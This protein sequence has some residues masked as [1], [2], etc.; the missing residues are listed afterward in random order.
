[1][2]GAAVCGIASGQAWRGASAVN[3]A[4]SWTPRKAI[5]TLQAS[6]DAAAVE[7]ALDRRIFG[8]NLEWFN[9][10]GGLADPRLAPSLT[11]LAR[12]QGITV[13]RF[14]GGTLSDYYHW[15]DGIGPQ[16]ARQVRK[17]PTDSGSSANTYGSPEFFRLLKDTGAEG[18][19]TVN[20]GTGTAEEAAD[21]VAYANRPGDARRRADGFPEPM[22]IKLW[23]VGNELYLPGNPH[24]LKITVTPEVYAQRFAAF[25]EAMRRVDPGI[26]A[27]AIGVAN[28][29][30]GPSSEF[31][32]WTERILQRVAGRIDMIAVHNA[33][34]PMLF[35]ERQP[36]VDEVY[37]AL[38]A[39]PEAVDRS[40]AGLDRLIARYEGRRR[41]PVAV[42]EW[43]ALY[44]LPHV[45]PYWVDHVKTL[46][47]A[48]YVARLLQVFLSHPRVAVSNYFKF[49]DRTFMGWVDLN[50]QPKLPF[51]A[52]RLYATATGSHKVKSSL[53]DVPTYDTPGI[54]GIAAQSG[55]PEV[56]LFASRD[57]ST[58]RLYVNLV[59]RSL[60]QAHQVRL[61]LRGMQAT[62]QGELLTLAGP[63]PTA[64]NGRDIPPEW[65]YKPEYEPYTSAA[66]H[67]LDIERR[68]W[69][70]G[71]PIPLPPF[72]VATLIVP[73]VRTPGRTAP[74]R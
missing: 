51:H 63:E 29:H 22:G 41:I 73:D 53:E 56:T 13:F 48:V 39:A 8:T 68:P 45:D 2:V 27:I 43:G 58:G 1:M 34:F 36:S 7:H 30:V 9:N 69:Q 15:Q 54:G 57:T 59:N 5:R 20:A 46:G 67:S 6:V 64:H 71:E 25:S 19:I 33:Y 66:P 24:E 50:G 32:D 38:W 35:K 47:S 61:A 11:R 12:E 31:T 72:S 74:T 44:S 14:P 55:V 4:R 70:T 23:E 49:T 40:L 65:A 21:W 60:R 16:A 10:A 26:T 17:H 62:P 42:T 37:P 3:A 28:S 52:F 18:M